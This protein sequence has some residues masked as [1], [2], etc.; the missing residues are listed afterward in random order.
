MDGGG[1]GPKRL[2]GQGG[3]AAYTRLSSCG[4]GGGGVGGSEDELRVVGGGSWDVVAPASS[5]VQPAVLKDG[6][7]R[8]RCAE[9]TTGSG[10]GG[11]EEVLGPTVDQPDFLKPGCV[12][13][14]S[15]DDTV[16]Q[17]DLFAM[18]GSPSREFST[19]KLDDVEG[20]G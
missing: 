1:D 3:P 16:V 10:A 7:R 6:V 2:E 11:F 8:S 17:L 18:R 4:S 5:E 20:V 13:S 14:L 12:A 15:E 9:G 19:S